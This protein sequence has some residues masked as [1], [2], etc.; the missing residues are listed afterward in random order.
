MDLVDP[1]SDD[2]GLAGF[3]DA[4][5]HA[6]DVDVRVV[7][8]NVT[9]HEPEDQELAGDEPMGGFEADAILTNIQGRPGSVRGFNRKLHVVARRPSAFN[10]DEGGRHDA[11][12][13]R[14]SHSPV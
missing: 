3:L 11:S 5:H 13:T 4:E 10:A 14:P 1:N 6:G 7:T 8:G 12:R 9:E 2:E